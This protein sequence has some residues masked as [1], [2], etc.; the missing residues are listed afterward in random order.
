MRIKYF[1]IAR[2]YLIVSIFI[3]PLASFWPGPSLVLITDVLI[4]FVVLD[5]LIRNRFSYDM[6]WIIILITLFLFQM[7]LVMAKNNFN[8]LIFLQSRS[9]F[10][11]MVIIFFYMYTFLNLDSY[12]LKKMS[13]FIEVCIKILIGF[14]VADGIAIN[15]LDMGTL[16]INV[17]QSSIGVYRDFNSHG[18]VFPKIPNG[19]VFGAQHASILSV[20]G[21]IW[22]LP[23][24]KQING[25]YLSQYLWLILSFIALIFTITTTAILTL[26][27][28]LL[29]VLSI[30]FLRAH[31]INKLV[32]LILVPF[33]V[34]F[35]E[36]ILDLFR[37]III[38]R[39][40]ISIEEF[41]PKM[42]RY[43]SAMV[44]QPMNAFSKYFSELLIGVGRTSNDLAINISNHP[45]ELDIVGEIGFISLS[46][47]FGLI[48]IGILLLSY[49][50]YILKAINFIIRNN[51]KNEENN[52]I[53][54]LLLVSLVIVL[55]LMHY[56]TFLVPGVKQ[57]F[58]AVIALSFVLIRNEYI[59][60]HSYYPGK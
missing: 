60:K 55:S 53:F 33:V 47:Q 12:N 16:F 31:K 27:I 10:M 3:F 43:Y 25:K 39:Y 54:R 46:I 41:A 36:K 56:T 49:S 50:F 2:F 24:I 1:D 51:V 9:L 42:D 6:R 52:I 35:F 18:I 14:I 20:I 26:T 21:I 15:F 22:W 11:Y 8:V 44:E 17:F 37:V 58:A 19:L 7:F 57:L 4:S 48:F 23:G 38:R 32:F 59:K 13:D 34:I 5:I 45:Q 29:V 40:R 30:T 28:A